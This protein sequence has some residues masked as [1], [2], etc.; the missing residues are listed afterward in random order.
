MPITAATLEKLRKFDTPTI[1]NV[2]ELFDV[3]PRNRGYMD[4]RIRC[5]FPQFPPM[6]GF[7]STASFRSDAPPAG[8]D[9][10]GS[11]EQQVETFAAECGLGRGGVSH[12]V[13]GMAFLAQRGAQA[14]A[15]HAVVFYEQQAHGVG[16]SMR[17]KSIRYR[18]GRTAV[19]AV[20]CPKF[21]ATPC[22]RS[23]T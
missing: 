7:A 9:A 14:L 6:V 13:D 1:A 15:D 21:C 8:G 23:A 17:E 19:G 18:A 4:G 2:I 16:M 20:P 3:R 5:N 12:P 11:L 10:Y 22:C